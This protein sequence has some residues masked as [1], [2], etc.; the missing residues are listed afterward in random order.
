VILNIFSDDHGRNIDAGRW[1]RTPGF[2][3]H[4]MTQAPW[5]FHANPWTHLRVG[6]DGRFRHMTNP[7]PS[8]EALYQLCDPEHVYE[9]FAKDVVVNLEVA[10]LGGHSDHALIATTADALGVRYRRSDPS[11]ARGVHRTYGLRSTMF[12]VCSLVAWAAQKGRRVLLML[13]YGKE[14]IREAC[15]GRPRFDAS[16]VRWLQ[17][18][19]IPFVDAWDAHRADFRSMQLPVES[20]LRTYYCGHYNATGNLRGRPEMRSANCLSP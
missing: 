16:L 17:E 6:T 11:S 15:R 3:R 20:Y 9:A 7:Y 8:R 1:L 14:I 13:S 2:R 4:M 12:V 10:R 19:Q 18:R 5:F